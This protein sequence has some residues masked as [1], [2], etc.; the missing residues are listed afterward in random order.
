MKTYT[1]LLLEQS[2][3]EVFMA[4]QDSSLNT[5]KSVFLA[6]SIDMGKAENWQERITKLLSDRPIAV[7]NPRRDDWDSSWKQDISDDRFIEQVEWELDHLEKADAIA[8]YFDP[9][10]QAPITLLELGLHAQ[11]GKI[12]V[13]CPEGYWRRGNV[14]IV[15]RRYNVP[16]VATLE[17]LAK[18]ITDIVK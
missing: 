10:G 3:F 11:S 8:V 9:E 13:C 4:P 15:C 2:E 14:E 16:F 5:K 18:E 17:D 12:V 1:Q 7:F 6:G